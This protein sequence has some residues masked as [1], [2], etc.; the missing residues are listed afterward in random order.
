MSL[1]SEFSDTL[2]YIIHLVRCAIVTISLALITYGVKVCIELIYHK[3]IEQLEHSAIPYLYYIT[4]VLAI[5]I[6]LILAIYET[7]ILLKKKHKQY[8]NFNPE[9]D[10]AI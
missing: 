8:K 1:K 9:Y 5:L 2:H 4:E 10:E 7:L 3:P 6:F